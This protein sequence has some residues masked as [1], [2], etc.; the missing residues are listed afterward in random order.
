MQNIMRPVDAIDIDQPGDCC[1]S[2]RPGAEEDF[3]GAPET[4]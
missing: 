1:C 2:K 3:D 4:Q